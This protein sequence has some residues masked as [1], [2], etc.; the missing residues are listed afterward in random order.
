MDSE[1]LAGPA[2][3][4]PGACC[5]LIINGTLAYFF[6]QYWKHNPDTGS[7]YASEFSQTPSATPMAG[8]TDVTANFLSWFKWGFILNVCSLVIAVSQALAAAAPIFGAITLLLAC[9]TVCGG[10]VWFI[11]GAVWRYGEAGNVCSGDYQRDAIELDP[12]AGV[13]G[14][15]PYAW[16]SGK[17]LNI[18]YMTIFIILA[19][20]C[21]IACTCMIVGGGLAAASN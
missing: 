1:K 8:Y 11:I 14:E 9:P 10:L 2:V 4:L 20:N 5:N 21:C 12:T 7:C 13:I 16:K 17:F 3:A 19:I 18:Y 6:Y 15:T